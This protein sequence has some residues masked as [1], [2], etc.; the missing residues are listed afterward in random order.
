MSVWKEWSKGLL[1]A[2]GLYDPARKLWDRRPN[3]RILCWN[4][5]YR[6]AGASD[7]LPI[8]P[9]RLIY[10]VVN[11]RE[12]SWF[13]Q[14][15]KMGQQSILHALQRN[16]R[17]MENF[18]AV[19]DFGCGCGRIMRHWKSLT[20]HHLYGTDYNPDLVGW[21]QRELGGIAEFKRNQLTPP[22]DYEDEKFDF[23][24]AISVF[25]HLTEALQYA[26]MNELTRVLK[27]GGLLLLTVHGESRLYQLEPEEQQR[28]LSGQLVIKHE[29]AEGTNVCGAYHP[30]Q[31][32]RDNLAKGLE[33]VDFI[34]RGA[35]NANQDIFLL[36]KPTSRKES[37]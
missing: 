4:A 1:L 26:W 7:N 11:S 31:W 16:G 29:A 24:Y 27:P 19:L 33:V 5:G 30:A 21:C 2:V 37:G 12:I 23:I 17:R 6:L 15:S 32:V 3:L 20:G 13:L 35:R 10:L 22:L 9:T 25:T 36:R 14:S 18:E 34:P 8:P 28:F